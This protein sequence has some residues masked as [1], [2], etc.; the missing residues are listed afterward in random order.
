MLQERPEAILYALEGA[1][2]AV[3]HFSRR[4]AESG[5]NLCELTLVN[6]AKMMKIHFCLDSSRRNSSGYVK[7]NPVGA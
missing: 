5:M 2:K 3:H 1:E 7:Y 4:I 6:R